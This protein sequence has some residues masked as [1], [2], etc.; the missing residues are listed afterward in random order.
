M[1]TKNL[2]DAKLN[3]SIPEQLELPFVV[4]DDHT[5]EV[6]DIFDR[7]EYAQECMEA[8][9]A[10]DF[11]YDPCAYIAIPIESMDKLE[12]DLGLLKEL[13][14]RGQTEKAYR[15]IEVLEE[16]LF[17]KNGIAFKEDWNDIK[18]KEV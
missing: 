16:E 5:S 4:L 14:R 6:L 1:I 18:T 3:R 13:I 8:A 2:E 9:I 17:D 12:T 11:P 15:F 7:E 10:K